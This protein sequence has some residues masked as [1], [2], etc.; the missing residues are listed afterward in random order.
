LDQLVRDR[1]CGNPECRLH[2]RPEPA[3]R[4]S[5]TMSTG[6]RCILRSNHDGKHLILGEETQDVPTHD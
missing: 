6:S 4:C 5:A 1:D 2:N 3:P